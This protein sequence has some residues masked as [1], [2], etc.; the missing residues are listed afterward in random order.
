MPSYSPTRLSPRRSIN[1]R[2]SHVNLEQRPKSLSAVRS[3][4]TCRL[5]SHWAHLPRQAVIRTMAD[6]RPKAAAPSIHVL[7]VSLKFKSAE[8]KQIFRDTWAPLAEIVYKTEP[9]CL[10]YEFCDSCDDETSA[11]IYERY[12]TRAALDGKHQETLKAYNMDSKFPEGFVKD[13]EAT[14]LHY[15][16]SNVGHMDR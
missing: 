4:Y 12:T 7:M 8:Q 6:A 3:L 11:I 2:Q 5:Y 9:D 16:E 1:S 10:S 14:L 13:Y 15:T